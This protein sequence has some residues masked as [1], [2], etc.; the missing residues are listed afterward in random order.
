M[1][2][3]PLLLPGALGLVA[4]L[5]LAPPAPAAPKPDA[6]PR[7]WRDPL[8]YRDLLGQSLD[9]LRRLEIVEMAGAVTKLADMGPGDGWFHPSQS[10]YGW[11]WL[12]GRYDKDKDGKITRAEFDGPA[13]LFDRLDRNHDGVIKAD[14]F[15]WSPRSPFVFQSRI[16]GQMFRMLD[17]QA[18]GRISRSDWEALF[19][20]IGKGKA[21]ITPEELRDFMFPPQ[22]PAA[23]PGSDDPSPFIVVKGLVSG[24]FGSPF[25]GPAV[26]GRAP[27][28][29][30]GT[31]DGKGDVSLDDLRGKPVVLIFGSFT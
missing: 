29:T 15:D 31:P 8:R 19:G 22:A 24:E 27:P 7:G 2:R 4:A 13:E 9:R 26:G 16:A 3:R 20:Q 21:F 25:E 11:K 12:A 10:R 18:K 6:P 14:D 1:H 30:L 23:K 28:F 5:A 17:P